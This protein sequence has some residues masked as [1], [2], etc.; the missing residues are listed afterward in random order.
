MRLT[1]IRVVVQKEK[2][3]PCLSFGHSWEVPGGAFGPSSYSPDGNEATG[4]M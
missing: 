1:K 4:F 3:E 2:K